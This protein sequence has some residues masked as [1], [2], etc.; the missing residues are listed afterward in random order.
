MPLK[1][2]GRNSDAAFQNQ[3]PRV[4]APSTESPAPLTP[5]DAGRGPGRPGY[6]DRESTLGGRAAAGW[7]SRL[8]Q[9]ELFSMARRGQRDGKAEATSAAAGREERRAECAGQRPR[10]G[11]RRP[12]RETGSGHVPPDCTAPGAAGEREDPA[13]P[14]RRRL[15]RAASGLWERAV[16]APGLE[17]SLEAKGKNSLR[18]ER[19][20]RNRGLIKGI[21]GTAV[22]RKERQGSEGRG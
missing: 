22:P 3:S 20:F 18:K 21:L 7:E 13:A 10:S 19:H 11:Q 4:G 8:S 6:L 14:L 15:R 16:T 12:G 5:S 9:L 1:C 2:Q 17:E